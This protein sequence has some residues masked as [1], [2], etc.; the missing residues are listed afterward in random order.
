MAKTVAIL[1]RPNVGK[2][3]LF[4][5]LVRERRAIVAAQPGTTRDRLRAEV[6]LGDLTFVAVDTAGIEP[7]REE[8]LAA[9]A[10]EQSLRALEEAD[11]GL[12]VVDARTGLT[13][14]DRDLAALLRRRGKPVVVAVNKCE[15]RAAWAQ[16]QE[17]WALGLGA[18]VMISAAHGEGLE[19][20]A[21]ALRPY[22]EEKAGE[23]AGGSE[24]SEPVRLAIVGRPN[25]GKSSLLNRLVGEE[26]VLVAPV[27]GVT[28][29]AVDVP[30]RWRGREVLLVDTAGLRKRGKVAPGLERLATGRTVQSVRRADVVVL[31]MDA[32]AALER[33]DVAIATLALRSGKGLVLALNKWDLVEDPQRLLEQT[34]SRL[35][36]RLGEVRGVPVVPVSALFGRNL[37]RLMEA[38]FDVHARWSRRIGTGPL[39]RWLRE[40]V[41]RHPPPASGRHR[42]KL[43]YVTQAG[44]RPPTLLVFGNRPA[45]E[46]PRTYR[47]YLLQDFQSRFG[48]EGIPVRLELRATDNPYAP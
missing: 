20:L 11:V 29:D 10:R 38:V 27:P 14:W 4:N 13:P 46:L 1:G 18:P 25:T 40:A 47:R 23:D 2:S 28:R 6:R 39:N 30:W 21:E 12:L 16:A 19:E 37:D 5:R 34:R 42:P 41:A 45:A 32:T 36:H 31:V 26:R 24:E 43:R 9:R 8:E 44:S 33:Q 17:A 22:L 3:T 15:S 35:I 7:D 48:L